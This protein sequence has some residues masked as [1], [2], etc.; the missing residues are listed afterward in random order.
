MAGGD[1]LTRWVTVSPRS[2]TV[3][4]FRFSK[5]FRNQLRMVGPPQVAQDSSGFKITVVNDGATDDTVK[6]IRFV[7]SPDSAY[8]RSFAINATL[9]GGFPLVPPQP[10]IGQNDTVSV[11]PPYPIKPNMSEQVEFM[12]QEFRKD[13]PGDSVLSH[14]NG[15]T[16]R[17]RFNDGSEIEA[18]P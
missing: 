7:Q 10:G 9:W 8:M 14:I 13:Q 1:S 16:F 3:V 5:S 17:F 11:I 6:W 4:D 15:K 12:F 18:R 2:R